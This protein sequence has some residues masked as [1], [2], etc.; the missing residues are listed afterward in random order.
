ME[1]ARH[2]N[3]WMIVAGI[4]MVA[5]GILCIV[6]QGLTLSALTL[7]AGAG[8]TV[9]GLFGLVAYLSGRKT[10]GYSG[11]MLLESIADLFVGIMFLLNPFMLASVIPWVIAWVIVAAGII[12]VASALQARRKEA[13]WGVLVCSGVITILFGLVMFFNPGL[14]AI[15]IGVYA[16]VRGLMLLAGGVTSD[17]VL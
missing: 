6:Y 2:F 1:T 15:L 14:L 17:K 10:E 9:S 13:S 7:L 11:W 16:V 3:V 12:Q 4:I 8:F 5:F